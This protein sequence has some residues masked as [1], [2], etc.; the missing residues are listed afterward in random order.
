MNTKTL[1]ALNSE[2]LGIAIDYIDNRKLEPGVIE[3]I[4][5][6]GHALRTTQTEYLIAQYA[7]DGLNRGHHLRDKIK[8]AVSE[9]RDQV[10]VE[11]RPICRNEER[12][13]HK[14]PAVVTK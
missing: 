2:V 10:E 6:L 5:Q 11:E 13:A 3:L 12:V 8:Q 9:A 4:R 7:L 14:K 1:K